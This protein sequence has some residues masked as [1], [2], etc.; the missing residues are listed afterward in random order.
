MLS[1]N[2]CDQGF[3]LP[4][5]PISIDIKANNVCFTAAVPKNE[6]FRIKQIFKENTYSILSRRSN[7]GPRVIID[8]GANIGLFAIYMKCIDPTA[9]V[10]CFEPYQEALSLLSTN[11]KTFQDIYVHPYGLY[12]G[13]TEAILHLHRFN[14]GENSIKV[15]NHHYQSTA[16]VQLRDAGTAIDNLN[17]EYIDVLKI[18]TEGCETEV[19]ES[20]GDRLYDIDYILVEYHSEGDRRQIDQLLSSFCVFS[21]RSERIGVGT[22]NY[23]KNSLNR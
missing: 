6:I 19:L 2:S 23:I 18:D 22:V 4:S 10:H 21:A 12:R 16:T 1:D 15:H 13:E 17:L 14:S 9:R 7:S 8:V 3:E 5:Q 11:I 20:L